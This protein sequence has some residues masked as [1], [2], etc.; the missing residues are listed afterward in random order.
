MLILARYT[1][2]KPVKRVPL[3]AAYVVATVSTFVACLTGEP[4]AAHV[5]VRP[6]VVEA[7]TATELRVELPQL[8]AGNDPPARLDVAGEGLELLASRLQALVGPESRWTVRVRVAGP[9]GRRPVVLRA[10]YADG[11]SVDVDSVLTVV[12]APERGSFP[13][14]AVLA[15]VGVAAGLAAAALLLARRKAAW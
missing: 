3:R 12:P 10:I 5:D 14:G 2:P 6:G 8:R 7:G 9:P 11:R 1:G 4:A 13:L 15:G